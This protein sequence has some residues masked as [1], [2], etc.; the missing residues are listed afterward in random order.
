MTFDQWLL[1]KFKITVPDLLALSD[2]E[3]TQYEEEY[4]EAIHNESV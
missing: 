4:K 2:E 3:I 1:D